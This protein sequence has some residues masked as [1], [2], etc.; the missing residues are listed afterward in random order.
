M[1]TEEKKVEVKSVEDEKMAQPIPKMR[2]II[3]ETDGDDIRLV[4]AEVSGKI[5]LIAI[6][7]TLAAHL[8][9]VK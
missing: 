2:Q 1:E 5:E 8:N 4:K 3:V 9:K 7:Q 6:L